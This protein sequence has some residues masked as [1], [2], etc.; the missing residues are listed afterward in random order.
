MSVR[1]IHTLYP[2]KIKFEC[3]RLLFLDAYAGYHQI[4]MA[5]EDEEKT[6]FITPRGIHCYTC[7]PIGLKNAGATFQRAVECGFCS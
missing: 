4:K 3:D 6:A 1:R 5:V 7:M 2:A